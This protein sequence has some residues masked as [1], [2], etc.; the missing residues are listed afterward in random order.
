MNVVI[1]LDYGKFLALTKYSLHPL[2]L[3]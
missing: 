2:V 1:T 3:W